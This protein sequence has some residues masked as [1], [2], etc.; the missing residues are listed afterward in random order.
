M[1]HN[2]GKLVA[3][4]GNS[5]VGKT[6]LVQ[7]LAHTGD[8][9]LGIEQHN[10]RPFQNLFKAN[11]QFALSNQI[12]YLLLRAEQEQVL[13]M[14]PQT[15]LVDG[16]LDQDFHGFTRLFHARNMLSDLELDLCRRLYQF[17]RS[18]LPSPDL[19]IHI[20]AS[21][22]ILKQRLAGRDRVNIAS[23]ADLSLLDSFLEAWLMTIPPEKFIR[24]DVSS[25]S[26]SY[27]EVMPF[28]RNQIV[29]KL[30]LDAGNY[31]TGYIA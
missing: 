26:L 16:G 4:T 12:D 21:P 17:C 22:E 23:A 3:V 10:E 19:I 6:S 14:S 15:A 1:A 25:V 11:P 2:M 31:D 9:K 30:Q 29:D 28:L 24:L 18:H 13:R 5:G 27:A 8:F 7:A 20:T